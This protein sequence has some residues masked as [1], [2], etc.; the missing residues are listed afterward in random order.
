MTI[1]RWMLAL[2]IIVAAVCAFAF[3]QA[4]RPSAACSYDEP[5]PCDENPRGCTNPDGCLGDCRCDKEKQL[6]V[7]Y[8][9][10]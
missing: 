9:Y 5:Y 7:P 6:C 8:D 1:R 3:V 4:V 2:G 10:P